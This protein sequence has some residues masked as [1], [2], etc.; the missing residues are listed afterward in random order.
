MPSKSRLPEPKRLQSIVEWQ[1]P[2][3][4]RYWDD[5]GKLITAVESAFPGI[6]CQGLQADG[7]HF[8]GL[9]NGVTG[10]LFYW[11]KSFIMQIGRGDAGL[12]NAA[13][14]FWPL[15]QHG[16]GIQKINRLGHRTW[17]CYETANQQ[18]AL[19]WLSDFRFVVL[20]RANPEAL[21]AADAAG[22]V[23][24]TKL[25]VGGRRLRLEVN[26]GTMSFERRETHGVIVDV[27]ISINQLTDASSVDPDEFVTWNTGF[28][29]DSIE[30][31]FRRK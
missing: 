11:D 3:A 30:P 27:D 10:G 12:S 20:D 18:E 16:L 5:C 22:S 9:S 28:I 24:R 8:A 1:Y 29:R 7:F 6:V 17:L 26:A 14:V 21:G 31:M 23:L 13:S 15:I 25:E 4:H 2:R 19:R